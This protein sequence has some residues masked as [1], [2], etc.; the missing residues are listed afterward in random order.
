MNVEV[1]SRHTE[2]SDALRAYAMDRLS[3]LERFGEE[4]LKALVVFEQSHGLTECEIILHPRRGEPLVAKNSAGDPRA[5]VDSTVSK[6]ERQFLRDKQRRDD[7]RKG[8]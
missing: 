2:L 8:A 6:I 5:A 7:W 1:T 4:F 3:G